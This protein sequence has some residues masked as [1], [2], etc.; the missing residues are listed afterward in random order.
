MVIISKYVFEFT[1]GKVKEVYRG[2]RYYLYFIF[3]ADTYSENHYYKPSKE[4]YDYS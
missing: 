3:Q 2:K 4:I 1:E